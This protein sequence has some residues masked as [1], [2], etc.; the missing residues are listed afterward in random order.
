ML[1]VFRIRNLMWLALAF[2]L[3][4]TTSIHHNQKGGGM[5]PQFIANLQQTSLVP[6]TFVGNTF[7]LAK[8]GVLKYQSPECFSTPIKFTLNR[9]GSAMPEPSDYVFMIKTVFKCLRKRAYVGMNRNLVCR[10]LVLI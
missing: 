4:V 10:F 7:F 1:T 8:F 5:L 9:K 3:A 2:S 6:A